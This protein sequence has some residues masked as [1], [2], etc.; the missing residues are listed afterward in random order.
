MIVKV[1]TFDINN[2]F[3]RFNFSASTSEIQE[4]GG[5][6]TVR[7]EFTEEDNFRLRNYRGSLVKAKK[8]AEN[9]GTGQG[10]FHTR[11]ALLLLSLFFVLL[12]GCGTTTDIKREAPRE[13][14]PVR[15]DMEFMSI[16][17][18]VISEVADTGSEVKF[19]ENQLREQLINR[20]KTVVDSD[21][22]AEMFVVIKHLKKVS[23]GARLWW[24]SLAGKAEI[25]VNVTMTGK[26]VPP[27][28]FTVDSEATGASSAG[29]WFSGYG[30]ST[31]D[32]L[33]RT[34]TAIISEL[35]LGFQ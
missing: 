31:E 28:N 4:R 20:Q 6:I 27:L 34:A 9:E 24:G 29:D 19:L 12:N 23:K 26:T 18:Q 3:S 7:Y 16:T 2:L 17:V 22:D 35:F 13:L 1:E 32:L 11:Y 14:S 8:T 21:A 10:I 5:G 30:G 33:Q 15:T 25:R